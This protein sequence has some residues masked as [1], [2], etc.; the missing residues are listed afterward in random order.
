ME[1]TMSDTFEATDLIAA[2]VPWQPIDKLGQA[3]IAVVAGAVCI[4]ASGLLLFTD[5]ELTY[6]LGSLTWIIALVCAGCA[7]GTYIEWPVAAW[8]GFA[9]SVVNTL[10]VASTPFL[11][12]LMFIIALVLAL[13]SWAAVKGALW[14]SKAKSS[15]Q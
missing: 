13:G 2:F 14:K 9:L 12:I 6:R 10:M 4:I 11:P 5:Q 7:A 8:I 1:T 15:P 3:N